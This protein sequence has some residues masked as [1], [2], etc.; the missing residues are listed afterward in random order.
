LEEVED[1]SEEACI[2]RHDRSE[3]D[4]RR[5]FMSY[6]K[7]PAGVTRGRRRVDQIDRLDSRADQSS[8]ANTPD[9]MSPMGSKAT[10]GPMMDVDLPTDVDGERV[11][12]ADTSTADG[13]FTASAIKERRR[14]A[15]LTKR[16]SS[17]WK[18]VQDDNS[19]MSWEMDE[20]SFHFACDFSR[21]DDKCFYLK[22]CCFL[23]Y[24]QFYTVAPYEPRLFPLPDSVFEQLVEE[25][26]PEE[27]DELASSEGAVQ[28]AG[29]REARSSECGGV[30][31]GGVG[32]GVPV[33]IPSGA[34][35]TTTTSSVDDEAV[36]FVSESTSSPGADDLDVDDEDP[37]DPEWEGSQGSAPRSKKR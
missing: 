29:K 33:V 3:L 24:Q 31:A 32:G 34:T 20:V 8:G 11:A 30:A 21:S 10:D 27:D 4:E 28:R 5:K 25:M 9:P 18:F 13:S 14:T 6:L 7:Q 1:V 35:P 15:S 17:V 37:N 22:C 26:P 23:S 2:A 36:T 16:D 19:G 12:P